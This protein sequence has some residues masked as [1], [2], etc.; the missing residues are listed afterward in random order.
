MNI[1]KLKERLSTPLEKKIL[2]TLAMNITDTPQN[3][4]DWL[5]T[6]ANEK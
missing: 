5:T 1:E 4:I 3:A 2:T 6:L